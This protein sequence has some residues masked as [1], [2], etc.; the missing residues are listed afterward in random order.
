M[1]KVIMT[2]HLPKPKVRKKMAKAVQYHKDKSKYR[3]KTKH[4]GPWAE[5]HGPFLFFQ[6]LNRNAAFARK[7]NLPLQSL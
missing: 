1:S 4:K 3:R 5:T 6:K 7:G 2:L